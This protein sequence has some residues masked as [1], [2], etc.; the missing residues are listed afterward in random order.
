MFQMQS[1][2]KQIKE[3]QIDK[4][5]FIILLPGRLTNWK[6]QILFIEAINILNQQTNVKPFSSIIWE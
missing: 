5:K 6:G 3:W 2:K 1:C 4:N